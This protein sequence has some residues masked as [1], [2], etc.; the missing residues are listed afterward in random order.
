[1]ESDLDVAFNCSK[2]ERT[3]DFGFPLYFNGK[4]DLWSLPQVAS[5]ETFVKVIIRMIVRAFLL[6]L[7][8][9]AFSYIDLILVEV[10]RFDFYLFG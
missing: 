2:F 3:S 9:N 6:Y 10:L 1:M 7:I 5:F 8:V 4:V